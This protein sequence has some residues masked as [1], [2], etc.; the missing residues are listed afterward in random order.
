MVAGDTSKYLV[1]EQAHAAIEGEMQ[2]RRWMDGKGRPQWQKL[3]DL[4]ME[5]RSV[6]IT[7]SGLSQALSVPGRRTWALRDILACLD[8]PTYLA[9]ELEDVDRLLFEAAHDAGIQHLSPE[10]QKEVAAMVRRQVELMVRA[11]AAP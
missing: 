8:L 10:E 2:R 11:K 7:V 1:S 4:L 6:E 9:Q 3:R 5:R